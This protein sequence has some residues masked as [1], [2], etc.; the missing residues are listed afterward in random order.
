M[1]M[2]WH[3]NMLIP[4]GAGIRSIWARYS[5]DLGD[6]ICK[7]VFAELVRHH[8]TAFP[9]QSGPLHRRRAAVTAQVESALVTERPHTGCTTAA[10]TAVSQ[11]RFTRLVIYWGCSHCAQIAQAAPSSYQILLCFRVSAKQAG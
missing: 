7:I 2:P 3:I 5:R 6:V 10:T 11:T 1:L 8:R 4:L 9:G